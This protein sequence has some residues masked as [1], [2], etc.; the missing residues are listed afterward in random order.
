LS[1]IYGINIVMHVNKKKYEKLLIINNTTEVLAENCK[2]YKKVSFSDL[3]EVINKSNNKVLFCTILLSTLDG[4]EIS[5]KL[6]YF[7]ENYE[8]VY[9]AAV[10]FARDDKAFNE[11]KNPFVSI[12]SFYYKLFR[13]DVDTNLL[14]HSIKDS[15]SFTLLHRTNQKLRIRLDLNAGDLRRI[16][17]LGQS[18]ATEHDFDKLI[19]LILQIARELVSADG[20]SIYLVEH[21]EEEKPERIRFKKSV[22][23][24]DADEFTLPIDSSSIAGYV[25]M[26]NEPLIIDDVHSLPE[27]AEYL[28]NA[29]FDKV[30][31]YYTKS[32]MVIPM[33]NHEDEVIGILQLINRKKDFAKSLSVEEMKG[34]AVIPF[35]RKD[36][37]LLSAIG[38]QAAV[39]IENQR[40]IMGQKKLLESFIQ[41]IAEA[42]DSKSH[43]TGAHCE[44]VPILT[45][46][47]AEAACASSD[48]LFRDFNLTSDQWYELKIAAWLHDCGKITTPVHVMDKST[49]LETITDRVETVKAR[50]QIL[51]NEAKLKYFEN[52]HQEKQDEIE[53][54]KL[55]EKR[56]VNIDLMEELVCEANTGGEF[57]EQQKIDRIKKIAEI[58]YTI[59]GEKFDLL[60]EEE[61]GNLTI[62]KGTL[63][64]EER[65]TIN[66]HMVETASMLEKLPFP[67]QLKNV[68]EYAT[69]HHEKI[70]G[71]GYP[72][73]IYAGDMSL[74]ARM[75]VIADV[76]EALTA[77]DRPYKPAMKLSRAMEIMGAMKVDNHFD[78]NLFDLFITSKT[79]FK[80]AGTFL[81]DELIDEVNE[82]KLLAL[83]PK[84]FTLPP[85][86]ERNKRRQGFL[87]KYEEYL[88]ERDHFHEIKP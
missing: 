29:D 75:M 6:N 26:T 58:K 34:E 4:G 35:S 82:E 25:A 2:D 53:Q 46:M 7:L 79:Y 13:Y 45:L 22:L 54:Q 84:D 61:L 52:I 9:F 74:P 81:S 16:A 19:E 15:F 51:R 12:P 57:L 70:D 43:Y 8:H 38:G 40:L 60:N 78:P 80:Y 67:K 17:Y 20:G 73:G 65:I 42:I 27:D 28:F 21:G 69:G 63:T 10:V 48:E 41:L 24:L 14:H 68:P 11:F 37:E 55:Y 71:T 87:P 85:V 1:I 33:I 30:H 3:E 77:G 59:N 44:R 5:E 23:I 62:S 36:F 32:M 66:S 88:N 39:A 76:F 18:L 83:K 31:D 72:K 50:F 56:I 47:L 49:K 64:D 86:S